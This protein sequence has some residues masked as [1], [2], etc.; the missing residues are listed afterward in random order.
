MKQ[1]NPT[2]A[3]KLMA[4]IIEPLN[5]NKR[6]SVELANALYKIA[7]S[8]EKDTKEAWKK[9]AVKLFEGH[10]LDRYGY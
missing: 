7:R 4:H 6:L 5:S 9:D 10:K 3:K 8:V 1:L 2:Q